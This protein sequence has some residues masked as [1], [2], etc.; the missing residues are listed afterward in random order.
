MDDKQTDKIFADYIY[1]RPDVPQIE[2]K[3]RDLK[4]RVLKI[5]NISDFTNVYDKLCQLRKSIASN[6]NLAQIRLSI[7]V[8]DDFYKKE[9]EFWQR[10]DPLF[11]Q[12]EFEFSEHLML[13]LERLLA[14]G[15]NDVVDKIEKT[16]SKTELLTIQ[17]DLRIFC[18]A[19]IPLQEKEAKLISEYNELIASAQIEFGGKKNTLAQMTQY[20]LSSERKT[21][22]LALQ[23]NDNWFAQREDKIDAIFDQLVQLRTKMAK[24]LGFDNYAQM[25]LYTMRRFD[26][27]LKDVDNYR[28]AIIKYVVPLC[29][30]IYQKQAA[31]INLEDNLKFH[32]LAI[33]FADGNAKPYGTT[34]EKVAAAQSMYH[35]LDEETGEFFD[36]M[37]K[38]ELLE[39]DAKKG[40]QSGGY[41]NSIPNE[42]SPYIFANFNGTAHDIDVLTHEAGHAFQLYSSRH[43]EN[44]YL[45]FPTMEAAECFS[46][47]MEFFTW[48]YMEKFFGPQTMKYKYE[49]LAGTLKFLPY[50]CLV[51]NFQQV[52]YEQPELTPDERK[53]VWRKLEKIYCPER[54]YEGL[55]L[56]DKGTYWYRQ[57]HIFGMPFYYIDYTLAQVI[58]LQFWHRHIVLQ[59]KTA[60]QDYKKVAKL[61][62]KVTF[63]EIVAQA[64]LE[65]P[66]VGHTLEQ[67]VNAA[68]HWLESVDDK[69]L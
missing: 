34:K 11:Q 69:N 26:W 33:N 13:T 64:G 21:R 39:L 22:L 1:M 19:N 6:R 42:G 3:F 67:S 51:D 5:E 7:N 41:C 62:G 27:N 2:N 4:S 40:K 43:I 25:S 14:C 44:P 10:N 66:F 53:A 68:K 8:N 29:Q 56:L 28:K 60:W 59:D 52:I 50:G 9:D 30:E 20:V 23:A 61:G 36:F 58:A 16:L 55:P 24:N 17:Y 18:E 12:M 49:H 37:V 48:N 15:K 47:S 45:L 31:R 32:D 38:H 57:G 46:M 35:E 65:N 54:I 63:L